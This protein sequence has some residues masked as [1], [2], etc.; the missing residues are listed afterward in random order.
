MLKR[1]YSAEEASAAAS[2]L[3]ALARGRGCA[4]LVWSGSRRTRPSRSCISPRRSASS[5]TP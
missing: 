1:G 2:H 5:V 3:T 4:A